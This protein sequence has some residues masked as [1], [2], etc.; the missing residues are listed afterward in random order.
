MPEVRYNKAQRATTSLI[1]IFMAWLAAV[2]V[3]A[4]Y[5][6]LL[7]Y[8]VSHV[9]DQRINP[10]VDALMMG[11]MLLLLAGL[12]LLGGWIAF[13]VDRSWGAAGAIAGTVFVVYGALVVENNLGLLQ[14]LIAGVIALLALLPMARYRWKRRR[15]KRERERMEGELLGAEGS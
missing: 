1:S 11:L 4:A 2:L 6:A 14:L 9:V 8:A 10:A 13:R 15:E 5:A 7:L 3:M 12:P